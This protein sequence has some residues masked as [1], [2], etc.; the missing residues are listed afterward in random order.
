MVSDDNNNKNEKKRASKK[1]NAE[2]ID[3]RTNMYVPNWQKIPGTQSNRMET[4]GT[5]E[6]IHEFIHRTSKPA[7]KDAMDKYIHYSIHYARR[8]TFYALLKFICIE[9]EL[10][11]PIRI[12]VDR[13][14][15]CESEKRRER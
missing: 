15:E 14:E 7:Q 10:N 9:C 11:T 3:E 13:E 1:I 12:A 5:N 4:I 2:W 8:V 6:F